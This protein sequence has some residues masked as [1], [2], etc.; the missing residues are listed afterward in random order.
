MTFCKLNSFVNNSLSFQFS[1]LHSN[2]LSSI[3]R[4]SLRSK[5]LPYYLVII[6]SSNDNFGEFLNDLFEASFARSIWNINFL[7][8][9]PNET[10]WLMSTFFPFVESCNTLQR[11]DIAVLTEQNYVLHGPIEVIYAEKLRDFRQCPITAAVFNT[12][13]YI[14]IN[15]D[16]NHIT[17]DGID[18]Q[19]LHQLSTKFNFN[20]IYRM[21]ADKQGRGA[22]Y[23]NGTVT[24]CIKMVRCESSRTCQSL[25]S[26]Y[27]LG[28]RQGSK[29]YCRS[30]QDNEIT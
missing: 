28:G 3:S 6:T 11:H 24:G 1:I 27:C 2:V 12:P 19:I 18:T 4:K 9:Y 5:P 13:P 29:L 25:T 22:I 16:E 8:P 7:S 23:A 21:P 14:I 17:Y 30:I 10:A 15:S 26:I 20:L